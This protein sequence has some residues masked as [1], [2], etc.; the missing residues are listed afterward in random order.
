MNSSRWAWGLFAATAAGVSIVA[1]SAEHRAAAE[2]GALAGERRRSAELHRLQEENRRLVAGYASA[3]DRQLL[4]FVHAEAEGLRA[5][6][7]ALRR[8]AA[9]LDDTSVLEDSS[10]PETVSAGNWIYGG[11][12]TPRATIESVLWAASHG[13]VE[14]LAGLLGFT[15]E[16]R[17]KAESLFSQLPAA[18]RQE[19]GSPES[20]V[21]TLLAGSF[22]KDATAM[23]IVGS[24]A[25]DQSADISMRVDHAAGGPRTNKF[26]LRRAPDGWQLMIPPS[27]M[28]GFE[29]TLLG[30]EAATP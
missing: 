2:A 8:R 14:R 11:N 30:P 15:D 24:Q 18:S 28:T 25:G 21:A 20:V 17:T 4:S 29:K 27:I 12:A 5:R 9:Q 6:L 13:D 1:F 26:S 3:A 7:A 19:Y 10:T 23:T 22:P 16:A